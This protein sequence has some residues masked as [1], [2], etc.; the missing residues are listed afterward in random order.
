M[1]ELGAFIREVTNILGDE[2]GDF[3]FTPHMAN[4]H[5]TN[6]IGRVIERFT[7]FSQDHNT[8]PSSKSFERAARE[9]AWSVMFAVV[10]TMQKKEKFQ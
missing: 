9:T 1:S 5:V 2:M 3:G 7:T 6:H 4:V 10:S 8:S